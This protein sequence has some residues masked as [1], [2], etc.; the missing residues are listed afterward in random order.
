MRKRLLVGLL[1]IVALVMVVGPTG[2]TQAWAHHFRGHFHGGVFIGL[3]PWWWGGF[4]PYPYYYPPVT[5]SPPPVVVQ[6]SPTYIQGPAPA[7]NYWY[8]CPSTRAYYPTVQ[9]CA[10]NWLQVAPRSQ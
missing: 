7:Q 2:P 3:S 1:V 6:E 5:Y 4:Y 10:E 9:T 8:Y